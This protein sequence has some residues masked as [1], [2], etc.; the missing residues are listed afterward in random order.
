[1]PE[2][3]D[4]RDL[5]DPSRQF[6]KPT[7]LEFGLDER[8]QRHVT[9]AVGRADGPFRS[10]A[11]GGGHGDPHCGVVKS[12]IHFIGPGADHQA[13][14]PAAEPPDDRPGDD[15]RRAG[16]LEDRGLVPLEGEVAEEH[17][18]IGR[19]NRPSDQSG[20]NGSSRTAAAIIGQPT[21]TCRKWL[22]GWVWSWRYFAIRPVGRVSD[23]AVSVEPG[24]L[25]AGLLSCRIAGSSIAVNACIAAAGEPP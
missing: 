10:R 4:S 25:M 8:V 13:D 2:I 11:G 20:R 5:D 16:V 15:E 3:R 1:M 6:I 14:Q 17:D 18:R 24:S 12:S 7:L 9:A 23:G 21:P 22:T 19:R